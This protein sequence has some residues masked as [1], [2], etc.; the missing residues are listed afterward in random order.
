MTASDYAAIADIIR[1]LPQAFG[2]R[3][4]VASHFAERLQQR[5]QRFRKKL[6]LEACGYTEEEE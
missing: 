3:N 1:S 5:H 6:F 2:L 4:K